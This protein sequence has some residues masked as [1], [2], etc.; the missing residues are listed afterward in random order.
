MENTEKFDIQNFIHLLMSVISLVTLNERAFLSEMIEFQISLLNQV[1]EEIKG[2]H[3]MPEP[4]M[5]NTM[6][7]FFIQIN[8]ESLAM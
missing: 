8:F 4:E 5:R 2:F 7:L 6:E 1:L 3:D